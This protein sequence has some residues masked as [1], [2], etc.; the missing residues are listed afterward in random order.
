MPGS[1]I[2]RFSLIDAMILIAATALGLGLD[3]WMRRMPV[4][5]LV[6]PTTRL[7][8]LYYA[9]APWLSTAG[10]VALLW[11]LAVV[12]MR[13]RKPRPT[14]RRLWRQPGVTACAAAGLATLLSVVSSI[15][16]RLGP[17]SLR[18]HWESWY[19]VAHAASASTVTG[20]A[21]AIAWTVLALSG[22]W[23]AEASWIDRLGRG[24]GVTWFLL[25]VVGIVLN[26][27]VWLWL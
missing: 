2:R 4:F 17:Q 12:P 23:R 16:D 19:D 25:Y 11:S 10:C 8:S 13:L 5:S 1:A 7:S 3:L 24:L 22:A 21:I 15:P 27:I 6:P 20:P 9:L 14:R 26:S 18:E